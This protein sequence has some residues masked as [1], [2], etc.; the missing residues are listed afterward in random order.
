MAGVDSYS[1]TAA[2][3]NGSCVRR[4]AVGTAIAGCPSHRSVRAA[5]PH[6]VPALD[7][8]RESEHVGAGAPIA[9][10]GSIVEGVFG[11]GTQSFDSAGCVG[12]WSGA[13]HG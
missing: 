13:S 4:V 5:L 2:V 6:A 1:G 10:T 3:T 12:E 11:T 8:W 7:V 9:E